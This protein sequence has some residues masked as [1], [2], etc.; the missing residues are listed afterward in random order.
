MRWSWRFFYHEIYEWI[1]YLSIELHIKTYLAWSL[2]NL[3]GKEECSQYTSFSRGPWKHLPNLYQSCHSAAG[4]QDLIMNTKMV[5]R[6]KCVKNWLLASKSAIYISSPPL[7]IR[8]GLDIHFEIQI[9]G[10]C[11]DYTVLPAPETTITILVQ[12]NIMTFILS[13]NLSLISHYHM[14]PGML[15]VDTERLWLAVS[16]HQ[17]CSVSQEI[18]LYQTK[19]CFHSI[20]HRVCQELQLRLALSTRG[21]YHKKWVGRQLHWEPKLQIV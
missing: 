1:S 3:C 20:C 6:N 13:F 7:P 18:G 15:L 17:G 8:W 12:V 19:I 16:F 11:S 9:F 14:V 5:Y 21:W 2:H 10:Q 4:Q